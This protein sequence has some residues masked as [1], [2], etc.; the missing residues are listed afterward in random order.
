MDRGHCGGRASRDC[1]VVVR[2]LSDHPAAFRVLPLPDP[3]DQRDSPGLAPLSRARVALL[4]AE[5]GGWIL[6]RGAGGIALASLR[7]RILAAVPGNS[8]RRAPGY[9]DDAVPCVAVDPDHPCAG[10]GRPCDRP[11]FAR[12]ND[13]AL[14]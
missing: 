6:L 13:A 11:G 2:V 10:T 3:Q 5:R 9:R 1:C 7:G 8:A 12:F 4:L 14:C